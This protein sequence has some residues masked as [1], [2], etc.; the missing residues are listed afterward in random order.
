VLV[1]KLLDESLKQKLLNVQK[2]KVGEIDF[3]TLRESM[4]LQFQVD[5]QLALPMKQLVKILKVAKDRNFSM[6]SIFLWL[7]Y[8]QRTMAKVL[9][10]CL[11]D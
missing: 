11:K 9:R 6:L 2:Y 5:Y 3:D 10:L 8:G 4:P 7:P 1:I